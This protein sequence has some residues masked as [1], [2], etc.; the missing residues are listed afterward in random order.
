MTTLQN[1]CRACGGDLFAGASTED[2]R[3]LVCGSCRVELQVVPELQVWPF[4]AAVRPDSA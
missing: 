1:G 2:V 3:I 4:S